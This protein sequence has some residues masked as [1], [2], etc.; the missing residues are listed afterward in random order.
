MKNF[1]IADS[2]ISV[3]WITGFTIASIIYNHGFLNQTL[4][5]GY[6]VVGFWQSV[7]MIVHAVKGYFTQKWGARYIYHWIS[8]IAVVTIPAGSIWI[9]YVTA[10]F[11]AI[12]YTW[13]CY[14]ETFVKMKRPLDALK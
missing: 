2:W 12:Y 14:Y 8:F 7:S 11:M 13:M 10:P 5:I 9:L 1:K 3:I 4:L 6:F